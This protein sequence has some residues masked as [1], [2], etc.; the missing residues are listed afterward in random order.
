[1]VNSAGVVLMHLSM[2]SPRVGGAGRPRGIWHF[3]VRQRQIPHPQAPTKCQFPASGVTFSNRVDLIIDRLERI[4]LLQPHIVF[5]AT[6]ERQ[7]QKMSSSAGHKGGQEALTQTWWYHMLH[8]SHCI[9]R[10]CSWALSESLL[11]QI[12]QTCQLQL[13]TTHKPW[14][15]N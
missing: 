3:N 15:L 12:W 11:L 13:E 10:T 2:L 6:Q 7:Y 4:C 8:V 14:F 9:H 5:T 1:M